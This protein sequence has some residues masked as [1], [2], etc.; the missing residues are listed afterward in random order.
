MTSYSCPLCGTACE[1]VFLARDGVPV[2]QHQT[3][4]D[5][6]AVQRAAVGSLRMVA[7]NHCGFTFNGAFDASLLSY[8]ES[9]DNTQNCS[10]HFDAYQDALIDDIVARCGLQGATIVEIGCGKGHFLKKLVEKAGAGSRGIGFDPTYVG[11]DTALEGRLRFERSFYGPNSLTAPVDVVIC[12]HVIEHISDPAQFLRTIRTTLDQSPNALV[13]FETPCVAWILRH[14]VVWDFFYEHCS[15]FT[16][17]SLGWVFSQTGF[18]VETVKHVFGDQYLWLEAR[19]SQEAHDADVPDAAEL[20]ALADAYREAE[21]DL[22]T[23]LHATVKTLAEQGGVALWGA[24]AKGVT[25]ANLID[26]DGSLIRYLVDLNPVKQGRYIPGSG[27]Q[28]VSPAH[29][30]DAPVRHALLMNPNY[31]AEVESLLASLKVPTNIVDWND[32]EDNH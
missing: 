31:R 24:G 15:L 27:H 28:I 2:H 29:L 22:R 13:I 12:R 9:Y 3:L 18:T 32:C 25:L 10:S 21:A 6:D 4:A 8:D 16:A 11:P 26:R 14:Q 20:N 30:A 17:E 23:R 7:C 19:V 5:A 1:Q